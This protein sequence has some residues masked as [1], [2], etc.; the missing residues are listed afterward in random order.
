MRGELETTMQNA[1]LGVA[2]GAST[3]DL[4]PRGSD[5]HDPEMPRAF[6]TDSGAVEKFTWKALGDRRL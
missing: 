1:R 6:Q 5:W 2:V 4:A 3:V